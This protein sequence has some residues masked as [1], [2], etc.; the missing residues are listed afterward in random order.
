MLF[1]G[2]A[3]NYRAKDILRHTFSFGTRQNFDDLKMH[4]A[5]RY[6]VEFDRAAL[7]HNG[8]SALCAG[9]KIALPKNSKV[10]VN[11]FTC[12]AVLEA[13]KTAGCVPVF[14]DIETDTLH[15]DV[16][17]LRQIYAKHPDLKAIIIQ[18]SLGI[19]VD[20]AKIS[21]FTKLHN[22]LIIEDLAHCAG[23][24]YSDKCETGTIGDIVALSF[25]KGKSI[26]TISGGALIIRNTQ[27]K[28]VKQPMRR[29]ILSDSLR[30]RW[31]P[32]LGVCMRGA[33]YIHIHKLVTGLFL[34]L[35]FIERSAD[36]KLDTNTR[37]TYWQSKLALRQFMALPN[38]GRQPIRKH[39]LVDNR[40][41]L[42]LKLSKKGYHF[43]EFWYEKPVS[44]A[45]YYQKVH[46]PE[47]ECPNSVRITQKI[48]NVP[49]YYTKTELSPALKIIKEFQNG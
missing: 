10:L 14:A 34:K 25:G 30:D 13:V 35:H 16:K 47:Q 33:R 43:D 31:Y 11:G 37:L 36:A 24:H 45:R 1:L 28:M 46:F 12:H 44:P 3:A 42:L 41:E 17:I 19:P 6:G 5:L 7:F 39:F 18:N 23:V 22:L 2:A 29:P 26:D 27:I 20:I 32:F 40:D 4:L 48:I 9:L 38:K 49:I 8:R 21:Q 15:F